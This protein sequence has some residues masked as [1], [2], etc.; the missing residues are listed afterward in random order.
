MS[1]AIDVLYF[2][3]DDRA[4]DASVVVRELADV[5]LA[6]ANELEGTDYSFNWLSEDDDARLTVGLRVLKRMESSFDINLLNEQNGKNPEVLNFLIDSDL[7]TIQG[8]YPKVQE[9]DLPFI[10]DAAESLKT[11]NVLVPAGGVLDTMRR[12]GYAYKGATGTLS[13]KGTPSSINVFIR[14]KLLSDACVR[15]FKNVAPRTFEPR[16]VNMAVFVGPEGVTSTSEHLKGTDYTDAKIITKKS[17]AIVQKAFEYAKA[18]G[19]DKVYVAQKGNILK[20]SDNAFVEMGKK[21]S[22]ETGIEMEYI[23]FDNFLQRITKNPDWFR[24]VVTTQFYGS[25]FLLPL[26]GAMFSEV[27]GEDFGDEVGTFTRFEGQNT[28]FTKLPIDTRCYRQNNEGFYIGEGKSTETES[29]NFRR[30][31]AK[32]SEN[33]IGYA[34]D[35]TLARGKKNLF[36]LHSPNLRG[37]R[38]F[39]KIGKRLAKN[40]KYKDLNISFMTIADF[41]WYTVNQPLLVDAVAGTNLTMD[42]L[43]DAEASKIGGIGMMPSFNYTLETGLMVSEPGHGTAPDLQPNQIN[44]GASIWAMAAM[45]ER[46]GDD[47]TGRLDDAKK[48][49]LAKASDLVYEATTKFYAAG[50]NLTGDLGGKGSTNDVKDGIAANIKA[51]S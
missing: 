48:K 13:G 2:P 3:G 47:Q 26:A 15:D 36:I 30:I 19:I 23:I 17:E 25:D 16:D 4:E 44:P 33:L 35:D 38:L 18:K 9:G 37:D 46:M 6:R 39:L 43:T 31:T 50:E 32:M 28:D 7:A 24:V 14:K 34:L 27:E 40:E 22:A 21:W 1:N 12:V 41:C 29:I 5:A 20:E 8:K 11:L 49:T 45:L 10:K 42:F 51:L